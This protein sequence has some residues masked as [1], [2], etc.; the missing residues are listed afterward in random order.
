MKDFF[1]SQFYGGV[2]PYGICHMAVPKTCFT[3]D[4][5]IEFRYHPGHSERHTRERI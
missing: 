4:R 2:V 5:L 1:A 3:F